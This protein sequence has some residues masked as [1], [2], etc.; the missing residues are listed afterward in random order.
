MSWTKSL[1]NGSG[2]VSAHLLLPLLLLLV[3][4]C[5]ANAPTN[6][7]CERKCGQRTIG[8]GNL[9]GVPVSPDVSITCLTPTTVLPAMEFEFLIYEVVPPATPAKEGSVQE[10]L[11]KKTAKRLPKANISFHPLITGFASGGAQNTLTPSSDWCTDSCGF[12]KLVVQ[13]TCNPQD[14]GV[15]IAVPGMTGEVEGQV[16]PIKVTITNEE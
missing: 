7:P 12:A 14:M 2:R 4:A 15:S 13:P 9:A 8:G 6:A 16:K 3:S 11:D 1:S 10:S 5:S